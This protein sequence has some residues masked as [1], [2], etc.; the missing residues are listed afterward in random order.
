MGV[1]PLI[2]GVIYEV[3]DLPT[4]WQWIL[5]SNLMTGVISG[6]RW[7]V[8][9]GPAP[10]PLPVCRRRRGCCADL[11]R[12]PRLLPHLSRASRTRA[13]W[14]PRSQEALSKRYRIGE[15]QASYGTL[16]ESIVGIETGPRP[17]HAAKE[18]EIWALRDVSFDV[19]EGQ[20]LGVIGRNGAG[21]STLLKVLTRPLPPTGGLDSRP[22]RQPARGRHRLPPRAYGAWRTS[23]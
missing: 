10:I 19:P 18:R 5:S 23:T 8:V 7:A 4:K 2:S 3:S 1:L 11:P 20:V 17:E 14:R 12:R 22:R 13:R 16:R 21:K 9:G 6:W 15:L